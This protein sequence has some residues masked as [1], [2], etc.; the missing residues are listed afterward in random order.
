M[1]LEG[2]VFEIHRKRVAGFIVC[3]LAFYYCLLF[4]PSQSEDKILT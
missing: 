3:L 1:K 4:L 2:S